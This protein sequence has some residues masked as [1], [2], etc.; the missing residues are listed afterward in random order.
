MPN[1]E[2]LEAMKAEI[3]QNEAR[4]EQLQHQVQRRTNRIQHMESGERRAPGKESPADH[5]RSRRG[6]H[7]AGDQTP[8]R[9]GFL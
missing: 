7:L 3:R 4:I 9:A 8:A 6:E 1:H 5:Q 2:K